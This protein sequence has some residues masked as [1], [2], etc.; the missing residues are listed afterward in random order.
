MRPRTSSPNRLRVALIIE[1]SNAYGRGLLHGIKAFVREHPHWS[2][3]FAEGARL[4][5]PPP[6]L[7][8]WR[9]DGVIARIETKAM[10]RAVRAA[11]LPTVDVSA[12]RL[13]PG[14]PWVETDDV[15]IAGLVADHLRACG[16]RH[17]A[18]CGVRGFNWSRWRGEAFA[19]AVR[20]LGH[21]CA[22]HQ[23][24]APDDPAA[25]WDAEQ[26]ALAEWLRSLPKPVGVMAAYDPVG[27]RLLAACVAAGLAVPE[28]VAVVGVDDDELLCELADPPL[29]SVAPDT[30]RTAYA[31]AHL[32][33]ALIAGRVAVPAGAAAVR[34][35]PRGLVARRS[36]DV[37]AVDDP[38]LAQALRLIRDRAG[39]GLGVAD[40]VAAAGMPRRTFESC[41][42][43]QL[44]RS[45]HAELARWRLARVSDLLRDTDL[46]LDAIAEQCGFAH[47]EYVSALFKRSTGLSP[48]DFRACHRRR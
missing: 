33:D 32:L 19:A 11:G 48:R 46:T 38:R 20:Q 3:Y 39:C 10:A 12:A 28:E 40:L 34:V 21:A 45:P 26:D 42:R 7:A 47:A 37:T 8:R 30:R 22:M 18:F 15:A 31:A 13:L 5:R 6:W 23:H 29:T 4:D 41:F 2:V 35:P 1:T 44:G 16:L 36:T 9:G 27:Q 24:P 14:L 17:F 43:R 25:S